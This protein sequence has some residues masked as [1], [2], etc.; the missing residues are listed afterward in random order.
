MGQEWNLGSR[1]GIWGA[2]Q[3][4]TTEAFGGARLS[5]CYHGQVTAFIQ[6]QAIANVGGAGT[7]GPRVR[8]AAA[9]PGYMLS[10]STW[11]VRLSADASRLW[12]LS[13]Q[14]Q[15]RRCFAYRDKNARSPIH[16]LHSFLTA[17][18]QITIN[19]VAEDNI[20]VLQF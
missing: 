2:N 12:G 17:L 1:S 16:R 19:L 9:R 5:G 3:Y 10:A 4:S 6:G 18:V 11:A 15:Q 20:N 13:A 8:A 14:A 7:S